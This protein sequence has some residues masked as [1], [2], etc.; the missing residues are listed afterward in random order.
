[1]EFLFDKI[2][3]SVGKE[4]NPGYTA[5]FSLFPQCFRKFSILV[6]Y[7]IIFYT[8]LVQVL[9]NPLLYNPKM[10]LRK[11]FENIVR[12]GENAVVLFIHLCKVLTLYH[13]ISRYDDIVKEGL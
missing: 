2:E 9:C 12:E 11:N 8:G 6:M 5:F 7:L 13:T 1:M 10:I 3:N 4:G